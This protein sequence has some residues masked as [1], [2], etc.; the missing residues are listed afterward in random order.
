V[1]EPDMSATPIA[2]I[3]TASSNTGA[4]AVEELLTKY[5]GSVIVRAVYRSEEKAAAVRAAFGENPNLQIVVGVDASVP[6]TLPAAFEGATLAYIVTPLDHHAGFGKDADLNANMVEAAVAAGVSHIVFGGSWTIHAPEAVPDIAG[7]FVGTEQLL[8]KLAA[9]GKVNWTS[10]RGGWYANNTIG[11]FSG[12]IK[13]SNTIFLPAGISVPPI[14][15]GDIGRS[16]AAVIAAHGKGHEGKAYEMSGPVCLTGADFAAILSD[17]LGKTITYTPVPV[18]AAVAKAP[19]WAADLT[20][21]LN[22]A[23]AAAVPLSDDVAK[24]TGK[25]TTYAQW[26]EANKAAFL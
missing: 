9:E 12:P 11:M 17:V 10:I 16:A 7:R 24:L 21:Y 15:T 18:E 20:T 14:D 19:K 4:A 26:A 1:H 22:S 6:E 2:T 23:G 3:I 25:H 8:T 13:A 5:N